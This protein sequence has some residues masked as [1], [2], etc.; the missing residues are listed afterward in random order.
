MR[1]AA[2][3]DVKPAAH[4]SLSDKEQH[5]EHQRGLGEREHQTLRKL[6]APLRDRGNQDKQRDDREILKKE[7]ADDVTSVGGF[8]LNAFGENAQDHRRRRHGDRASNREGGLPRS[9][10]K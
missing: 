5:H 1:A 7:H 10:C 2:R 8:E 6:A 9:P 4:E 3:H